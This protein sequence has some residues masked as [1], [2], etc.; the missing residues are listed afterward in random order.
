MFIC[1]VCGC[2]QSRMD[3]VNEVFC[4]DEE[5]VL[6]EHIPA[7]ICKRCEEQSVSIETSEAVRQS[8]KG[9]TVPARSIR[10]RVFEFAPSG[11]VKSADAIVP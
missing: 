11:I 8:I 6:V 3:L 1:A 7:E 2:E 9:G 5:Y 4:V 10:M